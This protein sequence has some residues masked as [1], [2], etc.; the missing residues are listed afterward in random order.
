MVD[1]KQYNAVIT[2]SSNNRY[3][4][5]ND[6][7]NQVFTQTTKYE[8]LVIILNDNSNDERYNT[9]KN[10]YEEIVYVSNSTGGKKETYYLAINQL[11]NEL[12]KYDYDVNIQLDDD[13]ILC[14]NFLNIALDG[15]YEMKKKSS[16]YMAFSLH[17]YSFNKFKPLGEDWFD[18][19]KH[20]VDGGTMYS[21][22]L[23]EKIDYKLNNIKDRVKVSGHF[24][25]FCWI[26]MK[27]YIEEYGYKVY[28]FRNSLVKHN[29]NDDSRL[30]PIIRNVKKIYTKN[31]IDDT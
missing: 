22:E 16:K 14:E 30:H 7:L 29:G 19:N 26:R 11:W 27:E 4:K 6:L 23:M 13:F 15:Y 20:F 3:E 31:F 18:E 21:K 17:L 5:I 25:S 12:S 28:R 10:D 8:F 9:L 2:I 24:S 1:K